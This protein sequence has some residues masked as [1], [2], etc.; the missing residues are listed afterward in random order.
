MKIS[1]ASR[2]DFKQFS[3][4]SKAFT[5]QNAFSA[6]L[7]RPLNSVEDLKLQAEE[8]LTTYSSESR[9]VLVSVFRDQMLQ[10][11]SES[12]R[13]NLE[14][15]EQEQTV[16]ITTGHQL[17]LFG[18]PL[19][20]VYKVMHV[21]K[22]VEKFNTSSTTKKAVPVFWMASEEHDFEEIS[23]ATLFNQQL[24]WIT[25]QTGAV[26]RMNTAEFSEVHS[27]FSELFILK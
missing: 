13:R 15:L 11:A 10:F 3:G 2:S 1:E 5:N 21:V 24:K 14:L 9:A 18:G 8:K 23:S 16:T 20:L 19:Y 17:T 6:F 27:R 26:G 12:Q 7:H 25:E 4:F 22:L